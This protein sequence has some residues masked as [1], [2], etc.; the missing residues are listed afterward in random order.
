MADDRSGI[1]GV[2]VNL[3]W[4]ALAQ[5]DV[6]HAAS[7]CRESLQLHQ[8]IGDREGIVE[9]LMAMADV[10]RASQFEQAVRRWAAAQTEHHA[11]GAARSVVDDTDYKRNIDA[12]RNQ[13]DA[14]VFAAAWAEGQ[15]LPL[16]QLVAEVLRAES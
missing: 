5:G 14:H 13:L 2:L 6:V 16:E 4:V 3:A 7:R 10:A 9:C 8:E 11:I 15:A 12:V 1:A